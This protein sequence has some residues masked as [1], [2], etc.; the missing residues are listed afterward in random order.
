M[1]DGNSTENVG[2][3]NAPENMATQF[4]SSVN[5][6]VK[7]LRF[8]RAPGE[9][10]DNILKLWT[11]GGTLL[12]TGRFVDNGT[13]ASGWEEVEIPPTAV[14]AGTLYRAS[15]NTNTQQAKTNCGLGSGLTNGPLTA[16]QGF[17]GQPVGSMPSNGSCSNFF[18][19]ALLSW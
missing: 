16:W 15:V 2:F 19:D 9:T 5:G 8:Y 6:T 13:G 4:S 11:D 10:G 3:V 12:A 1:A 14:T 18:V 17:W 7:A